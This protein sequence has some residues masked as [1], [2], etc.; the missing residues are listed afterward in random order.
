[1]VLNDMSIHDH[2]MTL[3]VFTD[4]SRCILK[5]NCIYK[6]SQL[7]SSNYKRT[8]CVRLMEPDSQTQTAIV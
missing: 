4:L 2:H 1:M 8:H 7:I 5:N 3:C 6:V